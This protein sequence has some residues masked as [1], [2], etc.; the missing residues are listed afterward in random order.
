MKRE[1]TLETM[2]ELGRN[3][4]ADM[5]GIEILQIDGNKL[6]SQMKVTPQHLAP[7]GYLHAATVIAL[8]DTTCG[9]GAYVNLPE[10]ASGFTTLELKSNFIG[11][12]L[13]GIIY[14]EAVAEHIGKTTQV[15][16]ATVKDE[17]GKKIAL[18]R[19]TQM[20]IY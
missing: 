17:A 13:E 18:F 8:A 6:K 16:D 4:L 7:N 14:C 3:Y 12:C 10:T 19:C 15:W 1:I 9:W 2:N 5:L 20:I 11:T